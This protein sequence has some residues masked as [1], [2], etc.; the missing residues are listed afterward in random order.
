M[1]TPS[2]KKKK[3][4]VN[5][6]IHYW[7]SPTVPLP[8]PLFTPNRNSLIAF[9]KELA[10]IKD[11]SD[12]GNVEP[13]KRKKKAKSSGKKEDK[14]I[15]IIE[16]QRNRQRNEAAREILVTEETYVNGLEIFV[17]A[18]TKFKIFNFLNLTC[19]FLI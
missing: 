12:Y 1:A 10:L 17:K 8:E 3:R 13:P 15:N 11:L 14:S 4:T 7:E 6:L 19:R 9:E 2:I 18:R 16:R 5:S